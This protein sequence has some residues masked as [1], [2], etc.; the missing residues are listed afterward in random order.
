MQPCCVP[1]NVGF[2][3]ERLERSVMAAAAGRRKS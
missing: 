1:T 2:S 3:A